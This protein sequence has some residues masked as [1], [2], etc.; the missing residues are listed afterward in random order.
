MGA[1]KRG[2]ANPSEL[3]PAIFIGL[4][5]GTVSPF[6]KHV[7]N[8]T[9]ALN[10]WYYLQEQLEPA[11]PVEVALSPTDSLVLPKQSFEG[12]LVD[13]QTEQLGQVIVKPL[14]IEPA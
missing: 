14:T 7:R 10:A 8:M 3:D 13:Y 12:L 2:R 9:L 6:V 11:N 5:A 1:V 4:A